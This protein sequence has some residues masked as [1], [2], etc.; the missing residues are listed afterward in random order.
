MIMGG[1]MHMAENE[2]LEARA[3]T[4]PRK[5]EGNNSARLIETIEVTFEDAFSHRRRGPARLRTISANSC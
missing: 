4:N 5:R 2:N 3:V 1:K